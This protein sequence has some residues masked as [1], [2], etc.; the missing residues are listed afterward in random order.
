M[1]NKTL[2]LLAIA[3]LLAGVYA[4]Y[5]TDWVKRPAIQII[6]QIRPGSPSP[7]N[8]AVC[9]VAFTL[10]GEYPLKSLKV[11]AVD[12]RNPKRVGLP[13][14]HL[15][16]DSNSMPIQGLIYG[17]PIAGMKAANTNRPA[18]PLEPEVTYRLFLEAGK[19]K[20]QKD[21]RTRRVNAPGR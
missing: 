2:A 20:G 14:W 3:A 19:A 10:D 13:I 18:Q 9:T 16:S 12:P 17:L 6:S 15:I 5:F 4:Y 7:A 8:P 11:S 1:N 21:F